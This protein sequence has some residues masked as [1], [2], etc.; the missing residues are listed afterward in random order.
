MEKKKKRKYQIS[1][2]EPEEANLSARPNKSE[3]KREADKIRKLGEQLAKLTPNQR[4]KMDFDSELEDALIFS[5]KL[6]DKSEAYRRQIQFISKLL[7]ELDSDDI[8]LQ[9]ENLHHK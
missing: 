6:G 3:M 8:R 4:K 7:R 9:L 2:I 5:Q 1:N